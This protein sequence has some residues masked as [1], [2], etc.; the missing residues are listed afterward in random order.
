MP[1]CSPTFVEVHVPVD[2]GYGAEVFFAVEASIGRSTIG[3]CYRFTDVLSP[4]WLLDHV[5]SA[6]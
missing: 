1:V 3:H 6:Q 2:V 4:D 5:Q